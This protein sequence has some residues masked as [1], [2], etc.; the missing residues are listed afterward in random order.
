[1]VLNKNEINYI[2][3]RRT[4]K[5]KK[6]LTWRGFRKIKVF[7]KDAALRDIWDIF[8]RELE[9]QRQFLQTEAASM[10]QQIKAEKEKADQIVTAPG[11]VIEELRRL[12]KELEKELEGQQTPLTD[13]T[14]DVLDR[15]KSLLEQDFE[16][17]LRIVDQMEK[18]SLEHMEKLNRRLERMAKDL[19]LSEE[20]VARLRS[21]LAAAY[22]SGIAS[23]YKTVQGLS[24]DDTDYAV[25]KELLSRLFESNLE[26]RKNL[27]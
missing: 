26:I 1:M 8:C 19:R 12:F 23:I 18:G 13:G 5:K 4:Y 20:E 3:T 24:G 2:F 25:K 14:S 21:E 7:D 22:D 6:V 11:H 9:D 15:I 17:Q 10:R 16:E 27:T